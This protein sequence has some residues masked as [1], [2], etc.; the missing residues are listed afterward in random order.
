VAF[1]LILL[2]VVSYKE[3]ALGDMH[4]TDILADFAAVVTIEGV[5]EQEKKLAVLSKP[6]SSKGYFI[7]LKGRGLKWVVERPYPSTTLLFPNKLV[8]RSEHQ[9]R[10]YAGSNSAY[11]AS[12]SLLPSLLSGNVSKLE[13]HF[14]IVSSGNKNNWEMTLTPQKKQLSVQITSIMVK[15]KLSEITELSITSQEEHTQ[16]KFTAFHAGYGAVDA[17][18]LE[19]FK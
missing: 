18:Y 11:D 17:K 13:S 7:S 5:F 12:F 16:I 14:N 8:L 6:L 1:I 2:F 19:H 15:G 3:I 10:I 4:Y 9:E